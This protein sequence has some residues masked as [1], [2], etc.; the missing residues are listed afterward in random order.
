MTD[1]ATS[2]LIV[3]DDAGGRYL[4]ARILRRS[5]YRANEHGERRG[6]YDQSS[7]LVLLVFVLA[8]PAMLMGVVV[9]VGMPSVDRWLPCR[10]APA[11]CTAV[12]SDPP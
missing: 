11:P 8:E 3:D 2:I 6:D 12:R 10:A 5:G 1:A 4:K 9:V 7:Q